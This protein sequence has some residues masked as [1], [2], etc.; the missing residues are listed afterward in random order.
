MNLKLQ[1]KNSKIKEEDIDNKILSKSEKISQD[2]NNIEKIKDDIL[3]IDI[4]VKDTK[5]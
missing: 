3:N 1:K 4:K 5:K 2:L